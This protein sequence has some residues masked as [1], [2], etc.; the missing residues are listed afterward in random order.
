MPLLSKLFNSDP[1]FRKCLEQDAAHIA[2]GARGYPVACIQ[3]AVVILDGAKIAA[4]ELSG[5]SYGPSTAEAVLA[6]KRKRK[7]I[8]L[9]YQ[10]TADAIVG[11]MTI[12]RLDA[13]MRLRE[14]IAKAAGRNAE[15]EF[16]A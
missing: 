11:K 6:Y 1:A 3:F 15:F 12:A 16:S 8:N 7:I 4:L 14:A 13:D 5:A 10:T 2:P 9:S